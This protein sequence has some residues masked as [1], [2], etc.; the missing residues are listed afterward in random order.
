[1]EQTGAVVKPRAWGLVRENLSLGFLTRSDTNCSLQELKMASYLG[2][3]FSDLESRRIRTKLAIS[4][5]AR[6]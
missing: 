6:I 2:L 5:I 1:M 4:V 3:K